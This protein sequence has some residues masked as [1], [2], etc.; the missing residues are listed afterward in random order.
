MGMEQTAAI[1]VAILTPL[2]PYL[3]KA[4]EAVAGEAGKAIFNQVKT[5]YE[6]VHTRFEENN[7]QPGQHAMDEL[8]ENPEAVRELLSEHI[9]AEAKADP[10]FAQALSAQVEDLR[11]LLFE[12]LERKFRT[13]D[14][15][16]IY[17]R[18]GIGWDDLAGGE[19]GRRRKAMALIEYVEIKEKVPELIAAMWKVY[20]GLKC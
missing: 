17:F 13:E 3:I 19:V 12:C 16:E 7:D 5:L 4:G 15:E 1:I 14:L 11:I 6:I 8:K 20:P 2:S 18:M 9:V 10:E